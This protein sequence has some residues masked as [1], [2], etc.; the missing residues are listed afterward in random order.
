MRNLPECVTLFSEANPT[1]REVINSLTQR[2]GSEREAVHQEILYRLEDPELHPSLAHQLQ[3]ILAK[4]FHDEGS[5]G[6]AIHVTRKALAWAVRSE[7]ETHLAARAHNT[8]GLIYYRVGDFSQALESFSSAAK[9]ALKCGDQDLELRANANMG[10]IYNG[11]QNWQKAEEVFRKTY[12]ISKQMDD[13][14][15]LAISAH[16]LGSVIWEHRGAC[17]EA[18]EL[19]R[20]AF[21][22]KKAFG[23]SVSVAL[24]L[25]NLVG[26]LRDKGD[27]SQALEAL[28]ICADWVERANTTHTRFFLELN[29]GWFHVALDNPFRDDELGLKELETALDIAVKGSLLEEEA[30]AHDYLGKAHAARNRFEAAYQHLLKHNKVRERYLTDQAAQRVE[31]LRN[32]FQVERLE[33][34]NRIEKNRRQEV[35]ALNVRLRVLSKEKDKLLRL[36]SHD[37][38][39]H[40]G[41]MIG[42]AELVQGMLEGSEEVR[43]LVLDIYQSGHTTLDLL[44]EILL[45][46]LA[47]QGAF[48][49][50]EEVELVKAVDESIR[51]LE[52][53]FS[54]KNQQLSFSSSEESVFLRTNRAG[55]QRVL[56]NLLTNASKF[57][58][59]ETS[60]EVT[61]QVLPD[62]IQV[63]VIDHGQGIPESEIPHIFKTERKIS[64]R[65][66]GGELSSGIG[67]VLCQEIVEKVGAKLRFEPTAGGGSTFVISFPQS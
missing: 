55:F 14:R 60:V 34:E 16:N 51:R 38:R 47:D 64:V 56:E 28:D 62:A 45:H 20:E 22:L 52:L 15:M 48:S 17:E 63:C 58:P 3:L 61:L 5:F 66:T 2:V 43:S 8:L 25:N 18:L 41:G 6:E 19:T 31:N 29:R 1:T 36:L 13:S 57:S 12:D 53:I 26:I 65:P 37:L 46:G 23:E 33:R 40:I 49:V 44:D 59:E 27:F 30:R 32:A 24:T 67:L 50:I 10:L 4:I 54:R 39:S 35:E 11:Q 7:A 42:M 9:E 21:E